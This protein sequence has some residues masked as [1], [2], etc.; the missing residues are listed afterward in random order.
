[1]QNPLG[2]Y[3]VNIENALISL[4]LCFNT[5]LINFNSYVNILQIQTKLNQRQSD[6]SCGVFSDTVKE[7]QIL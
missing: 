6:N 1:M 4:Y 5:K 7:T 2:T 3:S